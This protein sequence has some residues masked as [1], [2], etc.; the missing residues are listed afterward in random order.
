MTVEI[1][2]TCTLPVAS[3]LCSI[4]QTMNDPD[5]VT[6]NVIKVIYIGE[7]LQPPLQLNDT[8][9]I[10]NST[11]LNISERQFGSQYG[12]TVIMGISFLVLL[13]A[14]ISVFL[15]T[16]L[17]WRSTKNIIKESNVPGVDSDAKMDNNNE[18]DGMPNDKNGHR[19]S[20]RL[21]SKSCPQIK[22]CTQ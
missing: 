12:T 22:N 19:F 15:A 4:Q 13:C 11:I 5:F 18:D 9:N 7:R 21:A 2:L 6:P 17:Q 3:L 10:V 8:A 1:C 20:H 16:R 14:V